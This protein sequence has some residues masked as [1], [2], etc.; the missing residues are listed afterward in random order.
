MKIVFLDSKT[1][2]DA[3]ISAI[4][5]LGEY[6]AY[7]TST[8]EEALKRS[9]DAEVIIV[10]KVTVTKEMIDSALNLKLICVA[11]TGVN[12]IDLDAAAARGI[13]V[14]NVAGYSTDSVAQVTFAHILNLMCQMPRFDSFV[15]SG[16]YSGCGIFTNVDSLYPDVSGKMLG[17]VGMGAIGTKVAHIAE[18]FGMKVQYFSTSGT[19]HCKEYPSVSLDTLLSTSDVISVHAPLNSVTKGLIGLQQL[20]KM[21][22][23]AIIVNMARGGIVVEEDLAK[24]IS[25]EIIA[26]AAT[27]V[28]SK[29]PIPH[30]HPLLHTSHPERLSLTPHIAWASKESVDRLVAGIADNIKSFYKL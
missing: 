21:K 11:A 12:N 1:L 7:G 20:R 13:P 29:E 14:K 4:S 19:S 3:D 24:A 28:F 17:I 2:G 22:S 25:E 5:S 6:V 23:S 9:F 16:E 8:P 10:N 30:D 26:G 18:A 27:D 15:K